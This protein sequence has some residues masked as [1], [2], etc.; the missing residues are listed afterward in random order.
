M[1]TS[2]INTIIAN[3]YIVTDTQQV[4]DLARY[5]V[6]AINRADSASGTYL[7]VLIAALQNRLRNVRIK[8]ADAL[9]ELHAQYYES[10]IDGILSTGCD[11]ETA[12]RRAVF[13]RT[14]KSTLLS[15]LNAGGDWRELEPGKTSKQWLRAWVVEHKTPALP[16]I[17]EK[18]VRTAAERIIAI[19][20]HVATA[21]PEEARREI[22]IA[23]A[24]LSSALDALDDDE[25]SDDA[26]IEEPPVRVTKTRL[27]RNRAPSHASQHGGV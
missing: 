12:T 23:M 24:L 9:E 1:A 21:D 2:I 19:V 8:P 22:R 27:T 5:H 13:A 17:G 25:D 14:S 7:A 26:P 3:Q 11:N 15:F 4:A 6:L 18:A 16:E 10:V 20:K